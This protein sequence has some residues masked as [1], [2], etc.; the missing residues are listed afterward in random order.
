MGEQ[1]DSA[2]GVKAGGGACADQW[3]LAVGVCGR[4]VSANVG[5]ER[6]SDKLADMC[7]RRCGDRRIAGR[8]GSALRRVDG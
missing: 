8:M 7:G 5:A 6:G 2:A 4:T 1:H 3:I